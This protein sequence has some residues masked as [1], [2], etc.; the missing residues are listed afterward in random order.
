M[1]SVN[2]AWILIQEA[3]AVKDKQGKKKK[4]KMKMMMKGRRRGNV[5]SQR[6]RISKHGEHELAAAYLHDA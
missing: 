3:P 6:A 5:V 4:K 2:G 1:V